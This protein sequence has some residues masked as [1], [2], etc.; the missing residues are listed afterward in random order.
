MA[1]S[2]KYYI[3]FCDD[4]TSANYR[5]S[6]QFWDYVGSPTEL[7]GQPSP[8]KIKYDAKDSKTQPIVKS[9]A[10]VNIVLDTRQG[11]QFEEFW[12]IDEKTI[13]VVV[14]REGQPYWIGFVLP[15]GFSYNFTGGLYYATFTANDGL[16]TLEGLLF[17][18]DN[19]N[20]PY[21]NSNLTYNNGFEFPFV[22]IA[23][24]ILRK[25]DLDID[26]WTLI[27][28]Y[29][30]N[31][32]DRSSDSRD[33]D[34]WAI[35]Y[36]NVKTYI[37]ESKRTDIPY[38]YDSGEVWNC[39]KVL[40]NILNMFTAQVYQEDGVWKI[41]RVPVDTKYG[42]DNPVDLGGEYQYKARFNTDNDLV[43]P[44]DKDLYS[45]ANP[46]IV[47]SYCSNESGG[48]DADVGY[49]KLTNISSIIRI[50]ASGLVAQIIPYTLP[51]YYWHKYN[52]L[53]A[54]IGREEIDD[55]ATVG[56]FDLIDNDH[57][58]RMDKVYK[59]FRVN[60]QYSFIKEGDT[61]INLLQNGAFAQD[62][63]QYGQL[64]APP[65]WVR[66][67]AGDKWYPRLRVDTLSSTDQTATGGYTKG[68]R[69]GQQYNNLNTSGTDPNPAIWADLRQEF[70]M[71]AT[72]KAMKLSF[73]VKYKYQSA[74][75][76][77]TYYPVMKCYY[78]HQ[79]VGT[80]T[81]YTLVNDIAGRKLKWKKGDVEGFQNPVGRY[82]IFYPNPFFIADAKFSP[83][84][85]ESEEADYK[86]YYFEYD[87][88]PPPVEGFGTFTINGICATS[89]RIS[90]NFQPFIHIGYE[91][92]TEKTFSKPTVRKNWTDQGGDI[93]RPIFTGFKFGYI[94]DPSEEVPSS[95]Y[96]YANENVDYTLEDEPIEVFNGDTIDPEVQSG[97]I[98]PLNTSGGRN[99]WDTSDNDFGL[100]ASG[101]IAVKTIMSQYNKP[102]RIFEGVAKSVGGKFGIRYY[103]EAIPNIYFKLIGGTFNVKRNFIED[104]TFAQISES[105]LALG[106]VENGQTL[107]P[108]WT[109]TGNFRCVKD[110][111]GENTGETEIEQINSNFNHEGYGTLRWVSTGTDTT[112]CPIGEPSKYYWGTDDVSYDL[113]NLTDYTPTDEGTGFV[114]LPFDN[115]GG[116]Y[117]Y[118]LHLSSLGVVNRVAN[119]FQA[120]IVSSFQYYTDVTINGYLYRVLRQDFVTSEF[121]DYNLTFYFD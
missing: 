120:N 104:A 27:D 12:S 2:E 59:Q 7:T 45:T 26:L 73:W 119:D 92:V 118:L 15:D 108:I 41:K 68:L 83:Q 101:M 48:G 32:L 55:T 96:V 3:T 38:W 99:F 61:P 103:F 113:A 16:D 4:D 111:N 24:E 44:Q 10:S 110:G 52:T 53:A 81:T 49:Y 62:Y 58:M 43:F 100:A 33:S 34:P 5:V 88:E 46:L 77:V 66:W 98:V 112:S 117:I 91:G 25:L 67:R 37:E 1:Y 47:G 69:M 63:D 57:T 14:T 105:A 102:N 109:P 114:Q 121:S 11:T 82:Q 23:T 18:D 64:E 60:Y 76:R 19:T 31:M 93:P 86:W 71:D 78:V 30:K 35:S 87:V 79:T 40:E 42:I 70:A 9:K 75:N 115:E 28:V 116:K 54:Y 84:Y 21:G 13:K 6:I 80:M 106:G 65:N 50:G 20:E 85:E 36:V 90:N 94:P 107:S 97:I 8:L 95:D 51:V 56:C 74:D 39:K 89:G 22:L 17:K 72:V 29:E